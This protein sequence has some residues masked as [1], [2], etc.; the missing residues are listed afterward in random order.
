M[1]IF[2]T[3]DL[4][5][6]IEER[7]SDIPTE[8][9]VQKTEEIPYYY[10]KEKLDSIIESDEYR[11]KISDPERIECKHSMYSIIQYSKFEW[12][13]TSLKK[14][15]SI[16]ISSLVGCWWIGFFEDYDLNQ[17]DLVQMQ[18]K[19]KEWDKSSSNEHGIWSICNVSSIQNLIC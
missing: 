6:F 11:K 17:D 2:V 4:V 10:L 3:E 14:I 18:L 5:S 13:K 1:V 19:Q 15:L 12:L 16:V 8:I 7:R 9:I